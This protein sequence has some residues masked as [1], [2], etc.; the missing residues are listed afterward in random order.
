MP[1]YPGARISDLDL[2]IV[3][4]TLLLHWTQRTCHQ[5][6]PQRDRGGWSQR[7]AVQGAQGEAAQGSLC[8]RACRGEGG[9]VRS[10]YRTVA[11]V[12]SSWFAEMRKVRV[13]NVQVSPSA[14]LWPGVVVRASCNL[15]KSLSD[16]E[17]FCECIPVFQG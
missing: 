11:E 8:R 17:P 13:L 3:H 5:S 4:R 14:L 7:M 2:R 10:D 12:I 16:R 9:Q 1:V 6:R 15:P